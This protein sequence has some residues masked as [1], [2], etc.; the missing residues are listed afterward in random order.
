MQASLTIQTPSPGT[1][2]SSSS[3]GILNDNRS[4]LPGALGAT[5]TSPRIRYVAAVPSE[6]FQHE[7]T[8]PVPIERVWKA[9]DDPVTWESISGID[10]V[11]DPQFDDHDRLVGF[12]FD[13]EVGG[14]RYKGVATPAVREEGTVMGWDVKN[15]EIT[16]TTTVALSSLGKETRIT[17]TLRVASA[18]FLSG[19]LFP[20][21][22]KTI[23]NGLPQ[24]VEDFAAAL[25]T[26]D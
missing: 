2:T 18:G 14:K 12:A 4:L 15:S 13:T 22:A 20:A 16:G 25:N 24:T 1:K 8:S 9:L 26:A 23:G 21:I 19:M 6:T 5:A 17:V 10:R 11:Y 3:S 7:T